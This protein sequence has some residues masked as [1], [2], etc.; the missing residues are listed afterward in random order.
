MLCKSDYVGRILTRFGAVLGNSHTLH[1]PLLI[2]NAT[3]DYSNLTIGEYCHLGK[4]VF[5]DLAAA[6]TIE[7]QATIS[8]GTMIL[9]H[10]DVGHSP[11]RKK[12]FPVERSP[13]T[14]RRGAY[15]GAGA[16]VLQGVTVGE[17]AVVGAGAVVVEDVPSSS[18]VTGVP[19]R[20][21]KYVYDEDE[22]KLGADLFEHH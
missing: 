3:R 18:V 9:T 4:E 21:I 19:A 8:M 11:L 14:I 16:I 13:V 5:L 15:L 7:D 6:I 12:K 10:M 22:R 2:H 20:V 17:C 1:S